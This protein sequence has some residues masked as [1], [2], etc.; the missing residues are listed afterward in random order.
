MIL[1]KSMFE[2]KKVYSLILNGNTSVDVSIKGDYTDAGFEFLENNKKVDVDELKVNV[3]NDVDTTNL[4]QYAYTY[5]I[6]YNNTT[7]KTV[8][9]GKYTSKYYEDYKIKTTLKKAWFSLRL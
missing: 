4:G 9:M 1:S 6:T 2:P 7:K 8:F 5:E 3:K